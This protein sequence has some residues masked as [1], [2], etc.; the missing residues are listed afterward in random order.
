[1]VN[2]AE[3]SIISRL[4]L[5]VL[6][7]PAIQRVGSS[8]LVLLDFRVNGLQFAACIIELHLP[9]DGALI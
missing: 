1:M 9:I 8:A 2:R 3:I 4:R 5:K 7:S 6:M